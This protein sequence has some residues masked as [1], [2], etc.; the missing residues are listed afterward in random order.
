MFKEWGFL[1]A[2]IWVLL[3]LMACIGLFAG[4]LI[5]GGGDDCTDCEDRSAAKDDVIK[6]LTA[7]LADE[8]ARKVAPTSDPVPQP[9]PTPQSPP[10]REQVPT[11]KA[12]TEPAPSVGEKP[13]GI[14]APRYGLP[15]DL[16]LIKGVGKKMEKLC[17]ALGYYHF[18]QIAAWSPAE[19]AWVDDNLEG[20]KG[21][22]T[23]D[24]WV[25]QAQT[26]ANQ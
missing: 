8:R 1:L 23:R 18:D 25:S 14:D 11:P 5:W 16:T 10:T 19:V 26:L 24:D 21:R 7:D 6:R 2:E 4:W 13:H 22:V 9:S 3:A 15:D 17:N 12:P 20:F